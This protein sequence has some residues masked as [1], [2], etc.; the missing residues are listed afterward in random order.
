MPVVSFVEGYL[1]ERIDTV[2]WWVSWRAE[3]LAAT[4]QLDSA[5]V[6]LERAR[7]DAN[8]GDRP[9]RLSAG[10]LAVMARMLAFIE[11]REGRHDRVDALI[12]EYSALRDRNPAFGLGMAMLHAHMGDL[13]QA[14]TEVRKVRLALP[15]IRR[16][17][18]SKPFAMGPLCA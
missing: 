14:F 10:D 5:R 2:T 8:Y 4:G 12:A 7:E 11:I 3:L 15:G 6:I 13:E 1:A 18:D 16:N 17:F 9:Q